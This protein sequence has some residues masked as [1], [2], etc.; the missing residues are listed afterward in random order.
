MDIAEIGKFK[1]LNELVSGSDFSSKIKGRNDCMVT[2]ISGDTY[3]LVSSV[4]MMEG[5]HFDLTY[6]PLKHLGFKS[7]VAVL[8]DICAMNGTPVQ[9]KATVGVSSRFTVEDLRTLF[10]GIRTACT[11]YGV[12][13]SDADLTSSRTGVTIAMTGTGQVSKDRIVYRSGAQV[14]DLICVTGDLGSAYMGLKLL[15]REKRV[16]R[17]NDVAR[18]QFEGYEYLLERELKPRLRIDV[19]KELQESDILPTSMIDLSDGLASDLKQICQS[20]G[21]GARIYLEK[22]PIASETFDLSD[23]FQID[24]V[25]AALNGGDDYELLFTVPVSYY[26]RVLHLGGIDVIGHMSPSSQ[27]VALVTPDGA[28]ITMQAQGWKE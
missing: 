19:V 11:V 16:L 9:I 23:Q 4:L 18:P 28:E 6:T 10:D 3:L 13:L 7:V 5:I 25:V 22:I 1:L 2:D 17:G 12:E 20:S 8:S 15:E 26:E 27:G 24:P 21:C 14:N